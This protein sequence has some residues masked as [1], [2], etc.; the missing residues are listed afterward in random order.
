MDRSLLLNIASDSLAAVIG[1]SSPT[2]AIVR[3]SE[4]R[5]KWNLYPAESSE[6]IELPD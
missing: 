3:R 2:P 1:R 4:P 5:S 6:S